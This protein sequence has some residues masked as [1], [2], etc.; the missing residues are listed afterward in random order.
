MMESNSLKWRTLHGVTWLGSLRILSQGI[1]WAV[2]I[3]IAR[4]LVPEDYGMMTMAMIIV[5][6]GLT[7]GELGLGA[8]IIQKQDVNR[9]DLSSIFWFGIAISS[10]LSVCCYFSAYIVAYVFQNERVIPLTQSASVIFLISGLQIV[11]SNLLRKKMDFKKIGIIELSSVITASSVMVALASSGAGAWTLMGGLIIRT[12]SNMILF[13]SVTR[14]YPVLH[15]NYDEAKSYLI[16]G[17]NVSIGRIFYYIYEQSDR[18]FA[19]RFWDAKMLGLYSFAIELAQIPT[20]KV[21]VLINQVSFSAFSELQTKK[22]EFNEF[23]LSVV[24]STAAVVLPIFLGGFFLGRDLIHVILGNKWID[25]SVLFEYLC[26]TQIITALNAVN[27]YVHYAQ[28]RVQWSLCFHLALAI[29]MPIS[30]YLTIPYGLE[31][32]L[33]PWCSTYVILC[34]A[35]TAITIRKISITFFD[36]IKNIASPSISAIGMGIAIFIIS[37]EYASSK[38]HIIISLA[39]K[40]AAGAVSYIVCLLIIDRK[41]FTDVKYFMLH[42]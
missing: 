22:E 12:T 42:R 17:M 31:A 29:F 9:S 33:I 6:L 11:P 34:M 27:S 37:S 24:K 25:I 41:I 16:Y 14:W 21:V 40:I 36:Y 13:Y 32:I 8:A 19:G 35:W 10:I 4:L 2:T 20:E 1:S 30:F 28:G 18:Y 26:L 39:I 15:F 5:G 7:L 3:L 38:D 23:Y